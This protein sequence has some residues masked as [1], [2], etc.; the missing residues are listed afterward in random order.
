MNKKIYKIGN[1]NFKSKKECYMFT[2]NII[3]NLGCCTIKKDHECFNFFDDLL[4]NHT[5]YDTKKG[6]GVDYFSI[7]RNKYNNNV[8]NTVLTRIDNSKILFSWP[9]CCEFKKRS[10]DW[11]LSA[12]MRNS[13]SHIVIDFK[14]KSKLKCCMCDI[15]NNEVVYHVDHII[16]FIKLKN[17]FLKITNHQL[18][19]TFSNC[20][21]Y[22]GCSFS[23]EDID[24]KNDWINYHNDH[25]KLQILCQPCNNFKGKTE[26]I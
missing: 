18:P 19:K 24:F 7:I 8:F 23:D 16:P 14:C 17:D 25:C 5:E 11:H 12:S 2:K 1:K 9:H 15:S 22:D 10:F 26:M 20:P 21:K 6:S 3:H 4:K 13:I